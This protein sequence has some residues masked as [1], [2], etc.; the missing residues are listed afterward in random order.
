VKTILLGSTMLALAATQASADLVISLS[1]TSFISSPTYFT[2]FEGPGIPPVPV[3]LPGQHTV[4]YSEGGIT[5]SAVSVPVSGGTLEPIAGY[6]YWNGVG[7]AQWYAPLA[8]Y[9]DIRLTSGAN[10]QSLQFLASSG[11]RGITTTFIAYEVLEMGTFVAS[12]TLATHAFCCDVGAGWQ[13]VGFSGG[14]FDEVRVQAYSTPAQFDATAFQAIA[15]DN[16]AAISSVPGPV[17]GAGWPAFILAAL[18][19]GH[20]RRKAGVLLNRS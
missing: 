2:G 6:D 8:G 13:F 5:V 1:D 14:G 20:R 11:F 9:S 16:I 15:L 18:W 19:Y 3:L 4:S 17:V 10:F 12:G 7:Q